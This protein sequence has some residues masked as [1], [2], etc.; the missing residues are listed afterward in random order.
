MAA[1]YKYGLTEFSGHL[2]MSLDTGDYEM[3]EDSEIISKTE[4]Y[5]FE[6]FFNKEVMFSELTAFENRGYVNICQPPTHF[7]I[8]ERHL[9]SSFVLMVMKKI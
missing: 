5:L 6:N 2:V 4:E 8:V 7:F 3:I 9:C 1:A